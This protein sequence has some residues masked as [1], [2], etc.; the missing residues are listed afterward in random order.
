MCLYN[1]MV[2]GFSHLGSLGQ[3]QK[4]SI[5]SSVCTTQ[6]E[7]TYPK[8]RSCASCVSNKNEFSVQQ[9]QTDKQTD[10]YQYVPDHLKNKKAVSSVLLFVFSCVIWCMRIHSCTGTMTQAVL[11]TC[12]TAVSVF[13][14]F[15]RKLASIGGGNADP[16]YVSETQVKTSLSYL[17]TTAIPYGKHWGLNPG[18]PS[19]KPVFYQLS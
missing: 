9:R 7:K 17:A 11:T 13:S 12:T 4:V 15:C 19:G 14:I 6:R 5:M 10:Q 18:F 8:N 1:S 2:L 3:G 16:R